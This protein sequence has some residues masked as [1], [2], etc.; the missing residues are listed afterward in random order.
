MKKHLTL[1]DLIDALPSADVK[2]GDLK[3]L[4][5]QLILDTP[6]DDAQK[7]FANRSKVKLEALRLLTDINRNDSVSDYEADLLDILGE[8]EDE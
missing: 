5:L 8:K 3:S 6:D 1:A 2:S 7:H 4:I